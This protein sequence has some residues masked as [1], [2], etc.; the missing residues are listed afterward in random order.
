MLK[1]HLSDDVLQRIDA[2]ERRYHEDAYVFVLAALEHCQRQRKVRGHIGGEELAHACRELAL[3]QFGLL[4]RSVLSY[5]GVQA[6]GDFGRIV[7]VL[8]E[9]GL[10]VQHPTD[11][12]E[13]FNGVFDFSEVFEGG[14]PW[15]GVSRAGRTG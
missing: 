5:W 6:T 15:A 1:L 4:A 9:V 14:Y 10:L 8:I 2:L 3:E 11:R 7:F 12:P 13:H